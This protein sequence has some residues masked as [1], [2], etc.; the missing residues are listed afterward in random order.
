MKYLFDCHDEGKVLTSPFNENGN[1]HKRADM[2]NLNSNYDL[3]VQWDYKK[4]GDKTS[5]DNYA[6]V[7]EGFDSFFYAMTGYTDRGC[8][9]EQPG[10]ELLQQDLKLYEKVFGVDVQISEFLKQELNYDVDIKGQPPTGVLRNYFLMSFYTHFNHNLWL[11]NQELNQKRFR[12][13]QLFDILDKRL[14]KERLNDIFG[15]VLDI[16]TVHQA[17]MSKNLAYKQLQ[18]VTSILKDI[19]NNN[20]RQISGLNVISEA[21]ILFCLEMKHFDIPF[22]ISNDFFKTTRDVVDYI[23]HFPGYM[24]RP[25][26]LFNE[27]FRHYKRKD[28]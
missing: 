1:S 12:E 17:F 2:G 11:R 27:H 5:S 20:D 28:F 3:C 15:F 25:N 18:L 4:L 9:L 8:L 19:S 21:Y 26:N 10:I 6:I 14:L 16:D 23:D 24:K 7:W 13:I 22:L